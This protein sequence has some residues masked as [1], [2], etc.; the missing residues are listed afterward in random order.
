MTQYDP[1]ACIY[2]ICGGSWGARVPLGA[3]RC[4][5]T[6]IDALRWLGARCAQ[7]AW[8]VKCA[9]AASGSCSA[10]SGSVGRHCSESESVQVY[11]P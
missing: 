5:I 1:L 4:R 11:Q 7:F 6:G 3:T 8:L 9:A 2:A 10:S